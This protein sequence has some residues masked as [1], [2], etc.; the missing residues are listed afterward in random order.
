MAGGDVVYLGSI[1]VQFPELSYGDSD[2][3]YAVPKY[4]L[5]NRIEIVKE[6][7]KNTYPKYMNRLHQQLMIKR[8]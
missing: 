6:F 8:K 1:E 2:Y 4:V 7:M 5:H 3:E